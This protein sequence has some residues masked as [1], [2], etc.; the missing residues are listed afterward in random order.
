[1]LR[2]LEELRKMEK[3]LNEDGGA[4]GGACG[5]SCGATG[6]S[7]STTSS[8]LGTT[9][10]PSLGQVTVNGKA[11]T[12]GKSYKAKK[13]KKQVKEAE[14]DEY[15]V[16]IWTPLDPDSDDGFTSERVNHNYFTDPEKAK[17]WALKNTK[18][19]KYDYSIEYKD[20]IIADSRKQ[21]EVK[22]SLLSKVVHEY[23]DSK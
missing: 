2:I 8:A 1:M 14:E 3:E 6:T 9:P 22:E 11:W 12:S 15:H 17:E 18:N 21:E 20:K 4:C 16:E 10:T 5:T 7:A 23:M 13:K 19:G